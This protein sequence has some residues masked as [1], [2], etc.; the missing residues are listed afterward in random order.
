MDLMFNKW[1]EALARGGKGEYQEAIAL[2]QDVID[3]CERV[4]EVMVWARA[5]NSMGW[6][7]VELHNHERAMEWHA[8]AV[9]A[10]Q[11]ISAQD[12]E[13]EFNAILNLVDSL[14]VLNRLDEA[15]VQFNKIEQTV[16]NPQPQERFSMWIYTG[17]FLH[18]YGEF[19]L[20]RGY[21][22]K[23][24]AYANECVQQSESTGR[25][26]NIVKGRR[27]QGQAFLAQ[28][29]LAEAEREISTALELAKEIGNPPQLWK[30][31]QAFGQ[32]DV[33]TPYRP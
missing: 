5:L 29:K 3:T 22:D 9:K 23:A 25:R 26:K 31:H 11:E 28:G 20:A 21:I 30:T 2:L 4:G 1:V 7:L 32:T 33:L 17:H 6:V 16:R 8:R 24:L 27:L 18:S 10:A 12:P 19:W 14:M 15:E 13:I